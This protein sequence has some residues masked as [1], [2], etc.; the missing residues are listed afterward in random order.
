MEGKKNSNRHL[1][2]ETAKKQKE[3]NYKGS[4]KIK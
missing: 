2:V 3:E 1:M 4:Q